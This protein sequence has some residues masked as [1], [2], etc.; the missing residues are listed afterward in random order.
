MNEHD[1]SG[2]LL[3]NLRDFTV[4][5]RDPDTGRIH[6]TG[7]ALTMDG[8]VI[9]CAHVIHSI[10]T[11]HPRDAAN[12][13]IGV[14]FPQARG[15]ERKAY[16][17]TV[18]QCFPSHDDDVV[19]LQLD[20]PPPLG[21]EQLPTL[22]TA[23]LSAFH[24]FRSYGYRRLAQYQAGHAHGTILDVVESPEELT[25]HADPVQLESKQINQGMSGAGVLDTKRNLVVGLIAEVYKAQ[26]DGIDQGTGWAANARV[27]AIPPLTVALQDAPLPKAA[28]PQPQ[29]DFQ[30]V[31]RQIQPVP[32]DSQFHAAPPPLAE[33][34]GR[35][36]LLDGLSRDYTD[37]NR[38]VTGLIGFGGEGKSSLARKWVDSLGDLTNRPTGIF[39][40][41]FY[42]NQN[43]DE[44]FET[45]L[46]FISGGQIDP[47]RVR[48]SSVRAQV[49]AA[50]LANGR[51]VFVLDGL[52]VLQRQDGDDYGLL[53]SPDLQT[54]L[55]LFAAP[56]HSSFCL[57]TSRAPLLDLLAYTSYTHR[58]VGPVSVPD[59]RALLRELGVKGPDAALDQ[60]VRQWDGHALTLSLLGSY[61]HWRHAG[62]IAFADQFDIVG[63]RHAS[64]LPEDAPDEARQRYGHVHRVLRRYDEHLT[65]A[66]RAFMTLFSAFRT[67]VAPDAFARVFRTPPEPPTG[68][69]ESVIRPGGGQATGLPLQQVLAELNDADFEKLLTRLV[70]YRLLR[71]N[72]TTDTYTTHPL[73]RSHYLALLTGSGQAEQTHDQLK[74]YYLALAGDTPHQPTLADLAPLIEVVYHAC[75]A[76]AHDEAHQIRRDRLFQIGG[77]SFYLAHVLGSF[78]TILSLMAQFFPDGDTSKEPQ[79]SK[80]SDKSWI[81]NMVG[82]CLMSLGRLATAVPFYERHNQIKLELEDWQNAST[83]YQNLASL[84]AYLGRLAASATAAEEALTLARRAENKRGERTS[85]AY[86]AWAAHLRGQVDE[87]SAAFQQAEALEREI[88]SN[89]Q[90]LYSLRGIQHAE[91]LRRV[92]QADYARRVTAANLTICE[93]NRV[94]S[95]ISMCHRV[96]GELAADEGGAAAIASARDHFDTALTI[97]RSIS[98]RPALIEALLARGRWAAKMH[99]RGLPVANPGQSS[100]LPLQQAFADLREALSYATDGGYRLYEADSR[101]ALAW[102]HLAS[103]NPTEARQEVTRAQTMSADM[104]YHWGQVDAAE[105]LNLLP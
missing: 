97:A 74:E 78:E 95:Q 22:G 8:K 23:E 100:G 72:E 33:W 76:G 56:G 91:H 104:G 93:R 99:G 71:Y 25:L 94:V 98:Y 59:G 29:A 24:P 17:A 89:K 54:F 81:L 39:W 21:P 87:A 90:Y 6:G 31:A 28:A 35:T 70:G 47:T 103:G 73:V 13:P 61:L 46:A 82:A 63:S 32:P 26:A 62:D 49:I 36:E 16:R 18:A 65:A 9:T 37:P 79:V 75:R 80:A 7:L 27:L 102:A 85:L 44:F 2:T 64:T 4:Q 58:D 3:Q 51:Y 19:V 83:G 38:R 43:V 92:G 60:L 40:W 52:E 41:G 42:D 15:D 5:I 1:P 68:R 57:I 55:E 77:S 20:A 34:V 48:S 30:Q 69:G 88:D 67:P 10:L 66:E 101:I 45:A 84:N 53:R 50:L 86:Q 12:A 11:V 96:L 14:Y 105:I